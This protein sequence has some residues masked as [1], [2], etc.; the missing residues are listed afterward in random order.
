MQMN[1]KP[2]AHHSEPGALENPVP[3]KDQETIGELFS[4]FRPISLD[5][6]NK[7]AQMLSRIDNKYVVNFGQFRS[8]LEAVEDDFAILEI[9]ERREFTYLSCYYD[10]EYQ[11]YLEHHQGRRQR[12]KVRTRE[13][14][15]G[16]G[17][18]FFEVKLKGV[19]GLTAKHRIK[20]NF[21]IAPHIDGEY[22][23]MLQE[24]YSFQYHK[25]MPLDLSP[26]LIIGYKRCTLVALRGGERVTVDYLINFAK[27]GN[28]DDTIQVGNGFIIV[29]TKSG[30][31]KGVAD[32][33]LKT[34]QIRKASACSKYCIGVNLIGGVARNNNF[35]ETIERVRRNIVTD[36]RTPF[37]DAMNIGTPQI[38]AEGIP[39]EKN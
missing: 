10:D 4:A 34:L 31:G 33:A 13:Y 12:F 18:K 8:F 25:D 21:L 19:R 28:Q 38:Q 30:D 22:L 3:A 35:R 7:L 2:R 32:R 37:G 15:D 9:G 26:A 29:E 5:E 27:P 39:D 16:G 36:R 1:V 23:E 6:T 20:S 17:M 11:C 24:K 14:V